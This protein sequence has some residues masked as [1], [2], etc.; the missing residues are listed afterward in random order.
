MIEGLILR[1]CCPPNAFCRI[2]R[3]EERKMMVVS[4]SNKAETRII[5]I[6]KTRDLGHPDW[7][8]TR[9]LE[10]LMSSYLELYQK[11][12]YLPASCPK[13]I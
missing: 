13:E 2:E 3:K 10:P 5:E 8:L 4:L 1:I 6:N 7:Q 9:I 12:Y 11:A